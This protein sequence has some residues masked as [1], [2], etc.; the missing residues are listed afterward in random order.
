MKAKKFELIFTPIAVVSLGLSS[1]YFHS[2]WLV[3]LCTV[4]GVLG[5]ILNGTGRK[6]CYFF[7]LASS[8]MYACVSLSS[9]F[10]GEAILHFAFVSPL[11]LYS[12]L[13]WFRPRQKRTRA[14]VFHLSRRALVL[15]GVLL[16]VG[17]A[18]YGLVLRYIGSRQPYLNALSTV[19]A[20]AANFLSAKRMKEQW[21]AQLLSNATLIALW[22][23]A[24]GSDAG[25]LPVLI[26]NLLFIACNIHG[27]IVW[28]KM[29][30]EAQKTAQ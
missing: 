14:D 23:I 27:A 21:Y 8:L 6:Y 7:S 15:F 1:W 11:F 16:V 12:I 5:S 24:S 2:G 25:N 19:V 30:R 18:G 9:K 13:R 20:L 28:S 26:Q 17:T 4:L 22:L 3:L 29:A 10:Y